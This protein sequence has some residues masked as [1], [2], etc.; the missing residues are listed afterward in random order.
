M[1]KRLA[2]R[3]RRTME[4]LQTFQRI[5]FPILCSGSASSC[6]DAFSLLQSPSNLLPIKV[7]DPWHHVWVMLVTIIF[8]RYCTVNSWSKTVATPG[9]CLAKKHVFLCLEQYGQVLCV[10][11]KPPFPAGRHF[12]AP[13]RHCLGDSMRALKLSMQYLSM[14]A[15]TSSIW[16]LDCA[17]ILLRASITRNSSSF[18]VSQ[19]RK[20]IDLNS[21]AEDSVI[22][23]LSL[24][25]VA[26]IEINSLRYEIVVINHFC[27]RD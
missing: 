10:M 1:F 12:I 26:G 20:N 25:G 8:G 18:D 5:R 2:D 16:R 14:V 19:A 24:L 22:S 13:I 17:K 3:Y 21:R 7:N 23:A 15:I 27:V 9:I 6:L 11:E 4:F